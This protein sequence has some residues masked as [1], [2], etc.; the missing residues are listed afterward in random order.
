MHPDVSLR[1]V[2]DVT[3]EDSHEV[4]G[5]ASV[6]LDV[7]VHEVVISFVTGRSENINFIAQFSSNFTITITKY[8]E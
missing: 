8:F 1:F 2:P 6:G 5:A 4:C 3:K 7:V